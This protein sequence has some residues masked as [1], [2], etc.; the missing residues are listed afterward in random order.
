M[1]ADNKYG[2]FDHHHAHGSAAG[3]AGGAALLLGSG[4]GLVMKD[5]TSECGYDAGDCGSFLGAAVTREW[6]H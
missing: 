4:T 3:S 6:D 2:S 1:T 5:A